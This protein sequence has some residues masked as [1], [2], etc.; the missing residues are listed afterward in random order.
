MKK[1]VPEGGRGSVDRNQHGGN[2]DACNKDNAEI[3]SQFRIS[4]KF[5]GFSGKKMKI[6]AEVYPCQQ[7]EHGANH[8]D[9]RGL[10][11]ADAGILRRKSARTEG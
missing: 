9:C 11:K 8:L 7:H 3:S 5:F 1:T 6:Q 10:I 2:P 4:E